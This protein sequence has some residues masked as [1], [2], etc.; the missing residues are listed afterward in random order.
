MTNDKQ[1]TLTTLLHKLS[2]FSTSTN[3]ISD[4]EPRLKCN[5]YAGQLELNMKSVLYNLFHVD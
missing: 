4:N 2:T 1:S 3:H 5:C